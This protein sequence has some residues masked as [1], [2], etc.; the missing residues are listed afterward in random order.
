MLRLGLV[1]LLVLCLLPLGCTTTH[2]AST[3]PGQITVVATTTQMQDLVR[4]VGG[5]NVHLVGIL[6]PN[7]DPHDFEPS[8]STAI[9]LSGAKLVVESGVG[10]D[11]W[12][13]GLVANAVP[14][15]PVMIASQGLPLRTG[16][17]S[18]PDGDPH[19]W[20]D[21][22]LFERAAT[23]LGARLASIDPSHAGD[24]RTNARRYVARIEAM[25][26]ANKRLIATV[27]RGERKLVTNHDAFGYFAAHY[28]ITV[29]GSV[30][31]SLSTVAQPSAKDVADLIGTIRAEHVRAIFT[32]SSLS[33]ALEQQIASEAGVEVYAN[34]YGD[35]LGPPGSPAAT[36]IGMERWNMRAMVA[37]F[38]GTSPPRL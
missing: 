35:T 29:V 26:A 10:V 9:A 34:L 28:G 6:K 13:D 3:S 30:L 38:L 15:T 27:P 23:A 17:S 7:V 31:P 22:T 4:H 25:D 19:W 14:G 37:G 36:Y 18:E 21:P 1:P 11:S 8:P 2:I 32:E 33:P 16:D 12:V 5:D 20:H 24:Y